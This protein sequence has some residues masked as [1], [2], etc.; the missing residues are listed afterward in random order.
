MSELSE[1]SFIWTSDISES[2]VEPEVEGLTDAIVAVIDAAQNA[3]NET[4]KLKNANTNDM[5]INIP[6]ADIVPV[7]SE[8]DDPSKEP[9]K[10]IPPEPENQTYQ[11]CKVFWHNICQKT[12]TKSQ[13]VIFT[14]LTLFFLCSLTLVF[15][16]RKRFSEKELKRKLIAKITEIIYTTS[17]VGLGIYFTVLIIFPV[18]LDKKKIAITLSIVYAIFL[19]AFAYAFLYLVIGTWNPDLI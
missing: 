8:V 9:I 2:P 4:E 6:L 11:C 5:I 14:L 7:D 1:S 3:T 17:F 16:Y 13:K 12:Y 15:V 10:V 19:Q 18:K